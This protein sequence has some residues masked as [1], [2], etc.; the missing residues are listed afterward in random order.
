MRGRAAR[1]LP[2]GGCRSVWPADVDSDHRHGAEARHE[3][4]RAEDNAPP[5]FHSEEFTQPTSD[6]GQ[7]DSNRKQDEMRIL[8][9]NGGTWTRPPRA[10]LVWHLV[11]IIMASHAASLPAQLL[12]SRRRAPPQIE[13]PNGGMSARSVNAN[14]AA[15]TMTSVDD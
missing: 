15:I 4:E 3:S 5:R 14:S 10:D 12:G 13:L 1:L 9:R 8:P 2:G 6:E 7:H 11:R